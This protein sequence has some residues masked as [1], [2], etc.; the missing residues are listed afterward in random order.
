VRP[1]GYENGERYC[2]TL[3]QILLRQIIVDADGKNIN[4]ELNSP[5]VYVRSLVQ[6][7]STPGNGDGGSEQI[8]EGAQISGKPLTDH[9]ERFLS[10]LRVDSGGKSEYF[11]HFV[12]PEVSKTGV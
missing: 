9:V 3:L 10:M 5:F 11:G 8:R 4:Y 6:G 7:F 1:S 12:G 2:S